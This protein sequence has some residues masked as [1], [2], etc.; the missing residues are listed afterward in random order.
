M[1]FR[2]ARG[3]ELM[4]PAGC[5]ALELGSKMAPLV[6]YLPET[7]LD[8]SLR[9]GARDLAAVEAVSPLLCFFVDNAQVLRD[10]LHGSATVA[11]ANELRMM[12]VSSSATPKNGLRQQPLPPERDEPPRIEITR[13]QSPKP[14]DG[15]VILAGL[16]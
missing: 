15:T 8:D 14:H 2:P 5:T 13:M 9:S 3:L 4:K 16:E 1:N 12:A 10:R 7:D 6:R 11:K